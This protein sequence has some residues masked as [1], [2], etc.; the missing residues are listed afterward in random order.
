M[1]YTRTKEYRNIKSQI[2]VFIDEAK[3]AAV[4]PDV[5]LVVFETETFR[6][7]AILSIK[8]K[9]R[10]KITQVAYWTLKF[11][12]SGK[13]IKSLLITLDED[14]EFQKREDGA[15][16]KSKAIA[17]VDIDGTYVASETK[18]LETEKIKDFSAFIDDI[19]QMRR[20]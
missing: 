8:K 20:C 5:D 15:I 14:G 19:K 13:D 2:E 4:E 6:V 18:I 9:F 17:T 11:R 12:S 3:T 1:Y 7:I 10:E 16:R